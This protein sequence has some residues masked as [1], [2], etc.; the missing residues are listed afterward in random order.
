MHPTTHNT[1]DSSSNFQD[2][3]LHRLQQTRNI[4]Q[5]APLPVTDTNNTPA[6]TLNS[7]APIGSPEKNTAV[8][9]SCST[10]ED[11]DAG[12]KAGPKTI[13]D[14][15]HSGADQPQGESPTEAYTDNFHAKL[16]TT[17][18]F[19]TL[20]QPDPEETSKTD[21]SLTE[22]THEKSELKTNI[23]SDSVENENISNISHLTNGSIPR[24]IPMPLPI[25][26]ITQVSPMHNDID[27]LPVMN[28]NIET[29]I[30]NIIQVA[31]LENGATN[32]I[33][34]AMLQTI[35]NTSHE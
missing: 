25:R 8:K 10:I 6:V 22:E 27:N 19:V 29:P 21:G 20:S 31:T 30:S 7:K 11:E 2:P 34:K 3:S 24:I 14:V 23:S 9:M 26:N 5:V 4:V 16:K 28:R 32:H 12:A 17:T 35:N 33:P 15:P 1:S 13:I 18:R